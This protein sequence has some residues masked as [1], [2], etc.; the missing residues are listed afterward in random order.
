[1]TLGSKGSSY[2]CE[3]FKCIVNLKRYLA[4]E[5]TSASERTR[6]EPNHQACRPQVKFQSNLDLENSLNKTLY[7]TVDHEPTAQKV[8]YI[9]T[10]GCQMNFTDTEIVRGILMSTGNYRF[11]SSLDS[12][13]ESETSHHNTPDIILLMTCAIREGAE[14]KIW[15]RID[16]LAALE[17]RS[18][19]K[20][21]I[22]ILGCMAER[23]KTEILDRRKVVDIV[24][25]P[26]A[27]RDLPRLL[28]DS[29]SGQACINTMLS[30][31]ETY[32]DIAP[33]RIDPNKKSA[34]VSIMRGCNNMCAF[35]IVP[36]TRGRERSRPMDSILDEVKRLSDQGVKEITLLGQ[37][38]NSYFDE[39]STGTSI[40]GLS[41]QDSAISSDPL[42]V[43][44]EVIITGNQTS[45]MSDG[46]SS[47]C[48]R[49]STFLTSKGRFINL[50]DRVSRIDPT[51]RIRFTSPHP[52]DFPD[53]L[54]Y[55]IRDRPNI[56]KQIHLPAQSGSSTVL[57]RMRRGY[58]RE[59]YDNL[60]SKIR[61][62]IPS[63]HLST[64]IIVGFCGETDFEY[65]DTLRLIRETNFDM[66]YMFAYSM[67]E[68]TMAHRRFSDDVSPEIKAARLSEIISTFYEGLAKK[69][70]KTI[71]SIETVL[72]EGKSKKSDSHICGRTDGGRMAVFPAA[73]GANLSSK[74]ELK[75]G[76]YVNIKITGRS[77]ITPIGEVLD[78]LKA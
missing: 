37:N 62:V 23:L 51:I 70:E 8:V 54:L 39:S 24:C 20:L 43:V 5:S 18:K 46:F 47:V 21:R 12:Q 10:Y 9:E 55:L 74:L 61:Q 53:E 45:L 56:C 58:S 30:A 25:G 52:K 59:A 33:V 76:D 27:Y 1:L 44:D 15:S 67:R 35:C 7:Q 6:I 75:P 38:V 69:V 63:I 42:N 73:S 19:G 17:K 71:G 49:P 29:K 2:L 16:A 3:S 4:I 40:S 41:L 60:V 65:Q 32:A 22:G 48:K 64:D 77:G 11:V 68:K 28:D 31:D 66:A 26:D 13:N 50:L 78:V 72:V 34:F 36:F 14:A 57:E